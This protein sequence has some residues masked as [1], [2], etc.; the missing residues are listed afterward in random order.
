MSKIKIDPLFLEQVKKLNDKIQKVYENDASHFTKWNFRAEVFNIKS[1]LTKDRNKDQI[2]YIPINTVGMAWGGFADFCVGDGVTIEIDD[3]EIQ[4]KWDDIAEANSFDEVLYNAIIEQSVFWYGN[5][6]VRKQDNEIIIEQL[7]YSYYYPELSD[8]YFG[9]DPKTIH[10]ISENMQAT[11][12]VIKTTINAKVQ[13]YTNEWDGKRKILQRLCKKAVDWREI[14]EEQSEQIIDF[15]NIY[16]IDNKKLGN[17]YLWVS[18]F[19]D[20][21]DL[22][23]EINDKITQMSVEFIKHLRSKMSLPEWINKLL[24][25]GGKD[26]DGNQKIG[27]KDLEVY[28]H[29]QWEDPA[30]Y[31]ENKNFLIAEARQ[32]IIMIIRLMSAML[33][34]PS[35]F[36]G[37][38][39]Q[40]SEEKVE[41]LKI[42]MMR[43]LKKVQRKQNAIKNTVKKIVQWV[44]TLSGVEKEFAIEVKFSD[45]MFIDKQKQFEN[46]VLMNENWLLSKKSTIW[47]VLDRDEE[48]VD[49]ELA[50]IKE[51]KDALITTKPNGDTIPGKWGNKGADDKG[52]V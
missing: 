25:S 27:I 30:Q 34:C 23:E 14:I 11:Q 29:R 33:Q 41:A 26:A 13:T 1:F 16:R 44:M 10:I 38:D 28:V 19:L 32:H 15:L 40:G 52:T 9:E 5:I 43:F 12:S 39:E 24:E 36:F 50:L 3:E 7:P 6:R 51:E 37:V 31:I 20:A 48:S 35:S 22:A 4:K 21:L 49:K 17:R 8:I 46:F 42:K 45:D 47:Y 2:L 18:D